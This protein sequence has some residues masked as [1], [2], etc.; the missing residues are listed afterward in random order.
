[1]V[2]NLKVYGDK[3]NVKFEVHGGFGYWSGYPDL[4]GMLGISS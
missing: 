1:M 3:N 2:I 4:L